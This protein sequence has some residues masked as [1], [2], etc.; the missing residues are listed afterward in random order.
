MVE[1]SFQ[2]LKSHLAS[3]D[4]VVK[5]RTTPDAITEGSWGFEHTKAVFKQEIISF[6]K[7]LRDLFKD[8]DD[9]LHNELNEVKTVFNQME[10]VLKQCSVDKKY[11]DIQKKDFF[12]GN[13][14]LLEHIICQDVMNIV[15]YADYVNVNVLSA[16]NECLVHDNFEIERFLN[17]ISFN[18]QNAPDIPEFFKINEWQA[19][20]DAK[21]VSIAN[22]RKH[23]ESLKGKS[24]I[25]KDATPNKAKV[26]APG[27][28][29][30]DLEPLSPKVLKN[31]DAHIDYIKHTQENAYILWELEVLVYVTAT[32]PSITKPSEKLVAITPLN[33]SKKVRSQ[34]SGNTKNN[35]I[36]QTTSSNIKNKVEVQPRSVKSS[37]NKTN[38]VSEPVCN[39]DIKHTSLNK[40]TG[41]TF[42][43]VG[44]SCPL[45]RITSTKVEPLKE[46]TLKSVTTSN[47]EIKIYRRKTKAANSV[48]Q[49][50]LWYLDSGCS[51]H[52][53]GNRSQLINF[54]HKFLGTVRLGNDQIAKIMGYDLVVAFHKHT[55]YIR[56]LE[57]AVA[58]ACFTQNRS[59]IRK[60]HN[61][62]PYE[63]PHNKKP[64]LP[65]FYVF[66]ALCYPTNDS[67][68]LGK[69]KPKADIGIFVGYAPAKK[70]L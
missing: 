57:E 33:R 5:V 2:K 47:P 8:F 44:N 53:T 23:I 66:G 11:F 39:A 61:N 42:T 20:L 31:R 6:I 18:N 56:D 51:K 26:I 48:V 65:Y 41:R 24:V 45:T 58:T 19:K 3:F 17:N 16:N 13:D 25:E 12:L 46:T 49:I 21:D 22:M 43:I 55:C 40:P 64:N 29:K 52:M 36:S 63:L 62:T 69:L 10:A 28:F 35:K 7:T 70:A 54:V 30:L 15:M 37:L 4:K 60:R 14:R 67:E 27:L 68:D 34:P 38:R 50:I 9:G 1:T 32:C 59:L